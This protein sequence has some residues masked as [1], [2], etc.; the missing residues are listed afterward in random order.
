MT[1][2]PH[3][4]RMDKDAATSRTDELAEVLC[5]AVDGGASVSFLPPLD[6]GAAREFW[7]GVSQAVAMGRRILLAAEADGRLCGTV[8]I[9]LVDLPNQPHRAEIMKLLVH[10]QARRDGIGRRL[11]LAAEREALAAGR[12]LL[13]LD[14]RAGDAAEPL[15]RA[16][17]YQLAGVIPRYAR[18]GAGDLDD[19]AI[20]Y[21]ELRQTGR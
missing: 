5:D 9:G 18:N 10:R 6:R 8:Q 2:A 3:I 19:T 16:L 11:M 15:Y 4:L 20:Y 14:T 21:K 13:T 7:T 17:G 1:P 12:T